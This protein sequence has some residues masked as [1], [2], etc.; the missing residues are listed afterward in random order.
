MAWC[1]DTHC[2]LDAPEFAVDR[3]QVIE[4]AR[5]AGVDGV[6]I[7]AVR[8]SDFGSITALCRQVR[9]DL[10]ATCYTLGIH[11]IY[12]PMAIDSDL[13]LLREAVNLAMNDP[14]FVGIGEIGLDYFLPDLDSNRQ[15]YFFDEQL[16][17]AEEFD[18]PVVMH[19]RRSQDAIVSALKKHK[20]RGGIAHA[21]NGSHQQA[22]QLIKLNCVLG[23]GGAMTYPRA[24]QIR[25]LAHD[26]P[27]ESLVL[28]TDAPDIPPAWLEGARRNEPA[29]ILK[30]SE[31]LAEVRELTSDE[32]QQQCAENALRVI[33][34]WARLFDSTPP[35]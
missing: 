17:I 30:I 5:T 33:P 15:A 9:V 13:N 7:P 24:L 31:V 6:L 32:I 12:T 3:G 23:F 29:E 26:L 1:I 20:V 10:P 18:L 35:N 21:F 28:E 25:R 27:L 8:A 19:V 34:R 11:P 2:H 22:E 4:R 14:L 16:K